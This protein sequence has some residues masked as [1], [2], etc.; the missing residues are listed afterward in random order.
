M[1]EFR[2]NGN[3][4]RA[5]DIYHDLSG[6]T[7]LAPKWDEARAYAMSEAINTHRLANLPI[8]SRWTALALAY[9]HIE[10]SRPAGYTAP[11]AAADADTT[12]E[13]LAE[14]LRALREHAQN[15][16]EGESCY[17]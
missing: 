8:D 7:S 3:Y 11:G 6:L 1:T 9:L 13:R 2:H 15:L 10:S 4:A 16:E 14:V 17:R 12:I 5:F